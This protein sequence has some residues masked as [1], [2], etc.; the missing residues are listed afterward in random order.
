MPDGAVVLDDAGQILW[1]NSAAQRILGLGPRDVGQRIDN[2]I[3]NP[4]FVDYVARG[5]YAVPLELASP[6]QREIRLVLHVVPYGTGQRLLMFRDNTRLH[7]LEK[8]RRK[9]VANASHELRTPLT[10]L[11]GYVDAMADD[12]GIPPEWRAP[13]AEMQRQATRM[14]AIIVDLLELSRLESSQKAEAQEV[15]VRRVL[16]QVVADAAAIRSDPPAIGLEIESPLGL[17]GSEAELHSAFS[18][19]AVNAVKY[20]PA[21]GRVTVRWRCDE[22]GGHLEFIDTGIGI[23]SR[24][25]EHLTERFYRVDKG[26][27]RDDG[28]TGLGL[29]IVKHVLERHEARLTIES[30]PGRGSRFACHFPPS[31]LRNPT[32]SPAGD[33]AGKVAE[34]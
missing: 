18:N 11:S 23:E 16:E 21:G 15:D 30:E 20:T 4:R 28:G 13:V 12:D 2:L 33:D 10:V 3:R 27:S 5:D 8:I 17:R 9:F 7:Q 34:A 6:H 31:R 25:L 1:F 24:H 19:L 26:R 22:E 14:N 32:E 29:A